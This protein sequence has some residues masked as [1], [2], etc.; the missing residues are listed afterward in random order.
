MCGSIQPCAAYFIN[1]PFITTPNV[2]FSWNFT[3]TPGYNKILL[4]S[5]ITV[6][7]GSIILL[8]QDSSSATTVSVDTTGNSVYSD[9]IWSTKLN[10]L[11]SVKNWRLYL[12]ALTNFTNY[13]N[14]FSLF[15]KYSLIGTYTISLTFTS[16]NQIF[17]QTFNVTDCEFL[18]IL[19]NLF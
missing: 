11:S 6:P 7:K 3:I 16:S 9:M 14:I 10:S 18:L 4:P 12:T 19:L 8:L 15:H 13:E 2:L 5:P 17:Y 1:N